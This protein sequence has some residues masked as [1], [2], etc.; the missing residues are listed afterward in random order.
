MASL[1]ALILAAV[2][3]GASA[4][5]DRSAGRTVAEPGVRDGARLLRPGGAGYLA[6]GPA[7]GAGDRDI[8]DTVSS[9]PRLGT[10][11]TALQIAGITDLMRSAE[12]VL[13]FAPVD[14]AFDSLGED[15]RRALF[16]DREALMRLLSRHV[17]FKRVD[18]QSRGSQLP[19]GLRAPA[20]AHVVVL[21]RSAR[22]GVVHIVD[23]LIA[24]N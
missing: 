9:N 6:K 15:G 23:S 4:I 16:S 14:E 12:Q 8:V 10:F 11:V 20:A 18:A 5:E 19:V 1:M 13:V 7:F 2:A 3:P 21:D 22:N 17:R 24:V